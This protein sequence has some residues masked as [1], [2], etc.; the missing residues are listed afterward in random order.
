MR[1]PP[2]VKSFTI[3]CARDEFKFNSVLTCQ[4]GI[5]SLRLLRFIDVC[6]I[7][8]FCERSVVGA[9]KYLSGLTNFNV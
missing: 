4:L 6:V 7:E 5:S 8:F 1:A 9:R 2:G 3:L